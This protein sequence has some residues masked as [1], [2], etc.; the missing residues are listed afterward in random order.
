MIPGWARHAVAPALAIGLSVYAAIMSL[1]FGHGTPALVASGLAALVALGAIYSAIAVL[2]A[3]ARLAREHELLIESQR[4]GRTGYLYSD[5]VQ[6]RVYWSETLFEMRGVPPRPWF[7]F[8]ETGTYLPKE[9]LDR[10]LAAREAGIRERRAFEYEGRINCP[11]GRVLW[12]QSIGHPRFGPDGKLTGVIV[13]VQDVTA[14]KEAGDELRESRRFLVES[15]RLGRTGYIVSDIVLDRSYWSETIFEMRGMTPRPWVSMAEAMG[16][17][18][19]DDVHLYVEARAAGIREKR[20]FSAEVRVR[21]PDG[22]IM[23]E[24]SVAYPRF[25][26]DGAFV[27]VLQFVQD[28]TERRRSYDELDRRQAALVEV[29]RQL[30]RQATELEMLNVRYQEEKEAALAA[31]RAKSEFL[32]NMSHEL[33]TPLNA[34][35]GYSE[36]MGSG[37]YGELS[38]KHA[39]YCRDIQSA[40]H[41]LL[42]VINDLLD[43][44]RI[45]AGRLR[46]APE[47]NDLVALA[48]DCIRVVAPR[49]AARKLELALILAPALPAVRV[50]GRAIKQVVLNLLSNSIK[51]T[52]PGG[53]VAVEIGLREDGWIELRVV[54]DG[55]GIAS[56]NLPYVFTPFWQAEHSARR[57]HE[58]TGLGLSISRKLAEMHGG[59]L[60]LVSP[61]K[62]GTIATLALPPD[63]VI[64]E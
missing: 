45:E 19:P 21:R 35:I 33:R 48:Q 53:H 29:N 32:A 46:L 2:K 1:V 64:A 15:Q 20:G 11:D 42:E 8:A 22:S 51:F 52:E 30:E 55:S 61:G 63:C 49:A 54:D 43:M 34:V 5:L 41:H 26:E 57:A 58:G 44:S 28:V 47:E 23:W 6:D 10:Y 56:E 37:T 3:D 27:G 24:H 31:N 50:D 12:E 38:A 9:D 59:S 25:A 13:F 18:H 36:M 14:R 17:I 39:E 4:L 40:A 60:D 7:S 62:R 16:V